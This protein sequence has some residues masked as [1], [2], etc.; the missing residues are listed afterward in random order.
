MAKLSKEEYKQW[1]QFKS[2]NSTTIDISEQKLISNLHSKLFNHKYYVPC[3]CSPKIWNTWIS[4]I[5]TIYDNENTD[6]T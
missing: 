5:N 6:S 4:D 2:V 1:T 3:S